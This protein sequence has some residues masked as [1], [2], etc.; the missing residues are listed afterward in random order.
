VLGLYP[1]RE[2]FDATQTVALAFGLSLAG[3]AALL[4]WLHGLSLSLSPLGVWLIFGVGWGVGLICYL[5]DL[6]KIRPSVSLTSLAL[7]ISL[8]VALSVGLWAM[9]D[10]VAGQGS[11][12]Y[13]HTLIAQMILDQGRLPDDLQPYASLASFTYHFGFHGFVAAMAWF[14]GLRPVVLV[15]LLGQILN[16]AAALSAAFF[17]QTVTRSRTAA[18]ATA[19]VVSLGAV[20]PA[21]MM[22]WGRY[23]QLTGLVLLPLFLGLVWDGC[24]AD[25][26]RALIPLV[27]LLAAGIT[28]AHYRV[29]LM[30]TSG[31]MV[32]ALLTGQ[33]FPINK[34]RWLRLA[35]Y[36]LG[37]VIVASVLIVPWVIH[38]ARELRQGYPIDVGYPTA[39]YFALARLGPG[40]IDYSTNLPLLVLA[41]LG[42]LLGLWQRERVVLTMLAWSGGMLLFSTPRFAGVFMDT[43]SVII[44]LYFPGSV[45]IGWLVMIL[46][47]RTT[48]VT[49]GLAW[50]GLVGV[51]LVG[52]RAMVNI[53]DPTLAYVTPAD[54]PAMEWVRAN[55]SPSARFMVNTFHWDFLPKYVTG[56]DAGYWLPVLAN[57]RTVLP[58]LFYTSERASEPDLVERL[59]TLDRLEGHLTSLEALAAL[60]REGVTH[61]YVGQRSGPIAVGEL[62]ASPAFTLEYQSGSVFVF[63]LLDPGQP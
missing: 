8:A 30:A 29:A 27:G 53:A 2:R 7:W 13:H 36:L 48:R 26:D 28:L 52:A 18:L 35:G 50:A 59:V 60:K 58:P 46:E 61:V 10:M 45:V 54:L 32:V 42:L 49:R 34:A 25:Q 56:S 22:N 14:S 23:T 41:G 47:K 38:V 19:L 16:V 39:A 15:P 37:A 12:S 51:A 24:Q 62:L 1:R 57:R 4:A 40:V 20:L 31:A 6:R 17:V 9:R 21:F 11:D 5:R 33:W 44:A 55:T 43:V 3:W 63:K